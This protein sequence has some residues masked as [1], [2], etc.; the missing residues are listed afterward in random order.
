MRMVEDP[1]PELSWLESRAADPEAVTR[2]D[3]VG[4]E[5]SVWIL[6]AMYE[7]PG[8]PGGVTHDDLRRHRLARELAEPAIIGG[9][10]LDEVSAGTGIPLG[11][12]HAPGP[13]WRR[14]RWSEYATRPAGMVG[15]ARLVFPAEEW[16]P[17]ASGLWPARIRPPTEGSLDEASLHALLR[18]LAAHSAD[19][20]DTDCLS[21]RHP[22]MTR[23][24]RPV[25]LSGPLLAVC[26]LIEDEKA[27]Q[28]APN[29]FWPRDRSWFAWTDWDACGT[30]LSGPRGLID[31]ILAEADLETTGDDGPAAGDGPDHQ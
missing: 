7:H 5:A 12:E 20:Q 23:D 1:G 11:F 17:S 15:A 3:A 21:F 28:S 30:K 31:A 24:Y 18:V 4:W 14:L 25:L 2:Y 10:N 27:A 13:P 29:N 8:L 9:V 6:H 22:A 19:G 26:G 16:M